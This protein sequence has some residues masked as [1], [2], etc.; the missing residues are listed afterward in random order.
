MSYKDC[1][2]ITQKEKLMTQPISNRQMAYT[3]SPSANAVSINIYNPT[4]YGSA[5]AQQAPYDYTNSFYNMPQ[6]SMY[7]APAQQQ[8]ASYPT[9]QNY[10]AQ[11]PA[12]IY[13][14]PNAY[15]MPQAPAP[16]VM[17]QSVITNNFQAPQAAQTEPA[18]AAPQETAPQQA[19]APQAQAI[20][21]PKTQEI[22]QEVSQTINT[23]ELVNGLKSKDADTRAKAINEIAAYAQDVPEVSLQVLTE[24]IINSL[25]DI[26]KEDTSSLEGPSEQ[27]V[28]LLDKSAKGE[29]LTDSENAILEQLS[30]RDKANKNRIFALYTLA[31]IEKLQRDELD[32]Y[33]ENQKANGEQPIEPLK[34]QD[35]AGFGEISNIIKND[36][37]PEVQLAAIQALQHI[38]KPEDKADV[39]GILADS[40][41][42]SN[43][44]IKKAAEETMMKIA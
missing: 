31:M 42:S 14:Q 24:P 33:I 5:P 7:E 28:A 18:Q 43:E 34:L 2:E 15:Q 4:A 27:Q 3:P 13:N 12:M 38:E 30:P 26:I 16:E 22:P 44:A 9:Y 41:K 17:P 10:Q 11:N 19:V 20:Q 37:R 40:L 23:D 21:E 25:V 39:E 8:Y 32:Q 29:T 36:P 6:T 35:L 1:V